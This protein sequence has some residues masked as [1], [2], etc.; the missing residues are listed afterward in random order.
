MASHVK[1]TYRILENVT[2]AAAEAVKGALQEVAD[3]CLQQANETIPIE[4]GTLQ[5]SGHTGVDGDAV[6]VGYGTPYA[7][8]QH[9][10]ASLH[11]DAGRRDHWLEAT[12]EE[13]RETYADHIAAKVRQRLGR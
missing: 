8:K 1:F 2:E 6:F 11:H 5:A 12:V 10:D 7:L 13:N 3:V 9:E 4:E